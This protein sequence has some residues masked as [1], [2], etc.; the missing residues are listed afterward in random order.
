ARFKA[1]DGSQIEFTEALSTRPPGYE[2]NEEVTVLYDPHNYQRA[3][4]FKTK[5]RLYYYALL[6]GG[7]G[8]IFFIV[9]IIVLLTLDTNLF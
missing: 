3:R 5:W 6:F 8:S 7:L 1:I 2:V 9:Y 4:V